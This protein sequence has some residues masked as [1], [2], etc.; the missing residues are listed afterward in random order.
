MLPRSR[1]GTILRCTR[2]DLAGVIGET[3]LDDKHQRDQHKRHHQHHHQ[4]LT[5]I[6]PTAPPVVVVT[7]TFGDHDDRGGTVHGSGMLFA[8]LLIFAAITIPAAIA[9]TTNNTIIAV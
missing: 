4:H 8:L 1:R 7:N 9:A 3:E 2:E 6:A 5:P